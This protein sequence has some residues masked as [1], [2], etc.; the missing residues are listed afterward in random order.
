MSVRIRRSFST[1]ELSVATATG[2]IRSIDRFYRQPI[3]GYPIDNQDPLRATDRDD[4]VYAEKVPD[5]YVLHVT[6]ADVATHIPKDSPLDKAAQ[7]RAFTIYRPPARDPMFPFVLSEDR[8]SL[9]HE[10]QRLGVTITIA[11]NELFQPRGIRYSRTLIEAECLD[12]ATASHRMIVEGDDFELLARLARG[13]RDNS[14]PP[15][16]PYGSSDSAYM[17]KTGLL[18]RGDAGVMAAAKLVQVMMIFAN[19]EIAKFFNRTGLPFLYRNHA[20]D[21]EKQG[22][23]E[24]EP[25]DRGHY[26]LQSEGLTGAYSHCTSPIRRYADL[27]NQRMMHYCIDVAEQLASEIDERQTGTPHH[28]KHSLLPYIWDMAEE[29]F[30]HIFHFSR[31]H[32]AER[33]VICKTLAGSFRTLL[34]MAQIP[35]TCLVLSMDEMLARLVDI[36]LKPLIPYTHAELALIAPALN[37]AHTSERD[38]ITE[39]NRRNLTKWNEKIEDDLASGNFTSLSVP[40]FSGVLRR[41]AVTG[42]IN[43]PLTQETLRRF[44]NGEIDTVPDCYSILILNKEYQHAYWRALKRTALN[45]IERD[46]MVVNN[47]ME[48]AMKDGEIHANTYVVESLVRDSAAAADMPLLEVAGVEPQVDAALVVTYLNDLGAREYAAPHYSV[49]YTKKD[50]VRHAKFNFIR[51]LAFGELGPVDQTILP[52]PLFAELSHNRSRADVLHEMG[53]Q[54]GLTIRELGP[55]LRPDGRYSFAY[56]VYGRGIEHS[57]IGFVV[58]ATE[59]RAREKSATRIL[60]NLQFKRAYANQHPVEI[61]FP[62]H[63]AQMVRELA[64]LRGWKLQEPE[65][66]LI[67]E[68]ERGVFHAEVFLE[69]SPEDT[70]RTE[71][72]AR[73]KDNALQFCYE[74][75]RRELEKRGLLRKGETREERS[76]WVTWPSSSLEGGATI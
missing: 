53:R 45:V 11:L 35:E 5:G 67:R 15:I 19:N 59:Q 18:R 62:I 68:V 31:T 49:G 30:S 8:F 55:R 16:H 41:A 23:A 27:I 1:H 60:R 25:F 29:F 51:V 24:Y 40:A 10:Q 38:A 9:E 64:S 4:A 36:A 37:T 44:K 69:L 42:R 73:N 47:L 28:S 57:I 20:N 66:H 12:Y 43:Q 46:P 13:I 39:L 61:G 58:G 17:D 7:S 65:R 71:C 2:Y 63:P 34:H 54:M 75:L 70:I 56:Q 74:Q 32:A 26:A 76:H 48:K 33:A 21:L 52:I 22:R 14:R 72:E 50:T 6:I 3:R